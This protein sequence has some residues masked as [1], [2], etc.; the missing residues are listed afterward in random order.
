[1]AP[2]RHVLF[3]LAGLVAAAL[4]L[5]PPAARAQAPR[6]GAVTVPMAGGDVTILADR[7][8]EFG[9]DDLV[10]ATGNVEV[11]RGT[12]RLLA[13]R[14]ELNRATGDVVA[15]G[16]V[17]FYDGDDRLT[18]QRIDYNVNT[19]TGV[20]HDGEARAAP[21]YRIGGERMERLDDKRYLIRRGV[22]TTC[23]D[24]PP[25]WSIRYGT[26]H[27]D[28]DSWVWG[29]N[30]S[31]WVRNVPLIPFFPAFA[32][33]VRQERQSGFLFPRAGHSSAKGYY[34]EVPFYWAISDSQDATITPLFYSDRGYGGFLEYRYILSALNRG[35]ANVFYLNES[36][37]DDERPEGVD[38]HRGSWAFRHQW[39]NAPFGTAFTADINGVSDDFLLREYGDYL[40]D[41]GAQRVESTVFVTRAW[42]DWYFLGSLYWYQD[43]TSREDIELQRLPDLQLNTFATTIP[44]LPG[45]LYDMEAR[46]TNFV[47]DVGSDGPRLDWAA[48]V[49]R[50]IPV[51]G[52][53]FTITPVVGG[54]LTAYDKTVVGME[55]SPGGTTVVEITDSEPR[56]RRLFEIG[57]D[58]ETR[59]SRVYEVG[60]VWGIDAVLHTIEPRVGYRYVDGTDLV[61]YTR[62]GGLRPN[63]LPQWD[64]ID[65]IREASR[66]DY[67]LVQRLWARSVAPAGTQAIRWEAA[68]LTLAHSYE[69]L[70]EDRPLGDVLGELIVNP[71]AYFGLR[72]ATTYTPYDGGQFQV[73]VVDAAVRVPRAA[74]SIGYRFS[75]PDVEFV[76]ATVAADLTRFATARY[77]ANWDLATDTFVEN[78]VAVDLKWQC[79]ALSVE[80]VSR[81]D[82]EDELRFAVNLLGVGGPFGTSIGLGPLGRSGT[83]GVRAQ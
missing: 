40:H 7:F 2:A 52:G 38:E 30:A 53:V 80:Y 23:E 67:S 33:A 15:V 45:F 48:R 25:T 4:F 46:F 73:G 24:D 39:V 83:A 28:L 61:R 13:D 63:Q 18:G 44:G 32:A 51:A 54:R 10:I 12:Q 71:S 57:A 20:V 11:T 74:A 8:D 19:G 1:M 59:A 70:N 50:P 72:G 78:R 60:G 31:F 22:F 35:E 77:T 47:R 79:W 6:P 21:Y 16:D 75:D 49:Y 64:E 3:L 68:R 55:L 27:A 76:Q 65:A 43:L 5:P 69:Y 36:L 29:T 66:F 81:S 56:L 37:R 34:A 62:D 42:E 41:R 82:D 17:L 58:L 9:P 14:V 26:G